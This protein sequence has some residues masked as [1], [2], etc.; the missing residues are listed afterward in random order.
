[1]KRILFTLI[2]LTLPLAF[3]A[4]DDEVQ[5]LIEKGIVEHD[6]GNYETAISLYDQALDLDPKNCTAKYEKA[7]SSQM[8]QDYKTSDKICRDIIDNCDEE[9]VLRGAYTTLGNSLDIREKPK[10]AIEV[11]E[12]GIKRFPDAYLLHF[13]LGITQV[14]VGEYEESIQS[15]QTAATY[16]PYHASSIYYMG[17]LELDMGRTVQGC[18]SLMVFLSLEPNSQ[19]SENAFAALYETIMN[20]GSVEQTGDNEYTIMLGPSNDDEKKKYSF[21][22]IAGAL[23]LTSMIMQLDI[24]SDDEE[25]DIDL[26]MSEYGKF[27]SVITTLMELLEN[28]NYKKKKGYYWKQLAYFLANVQAS[29]YTEAFIHDISVSSQFSEDAT[30]WLDDNDEHYREY[31]NWYN[32]FPFER[33]PDELK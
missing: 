12:E 4:Q 11:Y 31:I 28:E 17:L 14:G 27:K 16:N 26:D 25:L 19:R 33:D 1:M 2:I 32:E 23:Q 22:E 20:M 30:Q 3:I 18:I 21:D 13:N 29:G 7:F 24:E 8:M 9:G 5:A 6:K 15:F 10:K